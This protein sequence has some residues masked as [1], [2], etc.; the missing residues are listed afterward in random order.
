MAKRNDVKLIFIANEENPE[1]EAYKRYVNEWL[2][3]EEIICVNNV[4]FRRLQE[5]FHF[6]SV[7]HYEVFTPDCRRVHDDLISQ[8]YYSLKLLLKRLK[9]KLK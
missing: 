1:N 7:P 9:E 3:D 6:S 5:L 2:A 4:D 8:G